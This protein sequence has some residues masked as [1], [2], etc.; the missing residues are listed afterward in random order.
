M[1]GINVRFFAAGRFDSANVLGSCAVEKSFEV[2][3]RFERN[4]K[5]K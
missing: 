2:I 4:P 3:S 5:L 1:S